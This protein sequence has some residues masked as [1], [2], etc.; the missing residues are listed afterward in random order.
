[1]SVFESLEEVEN[2]MRGLAEYDSPLTLKMPRETGK[3]ECRYMHLLRSN[4]T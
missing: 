3:K 2:T 4:Q 1:M